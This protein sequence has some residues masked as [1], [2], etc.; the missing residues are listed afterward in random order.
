MELDVGD[1]HTSLLYNNAT[2]K[3]VL[4]HRSVIQQYIKHFYDLKAF[5]RC[6][7]TV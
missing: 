7:K 5:G 2:V 4:L 6:Y 3:K 1:K